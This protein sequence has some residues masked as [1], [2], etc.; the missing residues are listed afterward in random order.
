MS[1]GKGR[2]C[3]ES[4]LDLLSIEIINYYSRQT[5]T[6]PQAAIDAIGKVKALWSGS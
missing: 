3:A 4:C 5:V 1:L 6:P 2:Q